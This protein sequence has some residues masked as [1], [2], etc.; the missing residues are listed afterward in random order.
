MPPLFGFVLSTE[1]LQVVERRP[2]GI[3]TKVKVYVEI[4]F[5]C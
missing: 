2:G 3:E 1:E 5:D 4:N